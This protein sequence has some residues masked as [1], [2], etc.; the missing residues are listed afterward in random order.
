[1]L[2]KAHE[3]ACGNNISVDW[4]TTVIHSQF[5]RKEQLDKYKAY[6]IISSR[7]AEH[8]FFFSD[9]HMHNRGMV[10]ASFM[11]PLNTTLKMG[12][13]AIH[14]TEFNVLPINQL[15]VLRC[16]VNRTS[17]QVFYWVLARELLLTR[18]VINNST[19]LIIIS[20]S[21]DIDHAI[22]TSSHVHSCRLINRM[23]F[24]VPTSLNIPKVKYI[25]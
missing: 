22:K 21:N 10:Q 13:P 18:P 1:M 2:L 20:S 14:H 11:S 19:L 5:V 6:S 7:Y 8:T 9:T 3:Y 17:A 15:M 4:R 25:A 23:P 24:R 16:A 12:V